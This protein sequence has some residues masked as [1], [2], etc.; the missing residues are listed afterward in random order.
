MKVNTSDEDRRG[1]SRRHSANPKGC[2]RRAFLTGTSAALAA[3]ALA[4]RPAQGQDLQKL[5]AAKQ[6]Q[7]AT[8]P[9]P[10]NRLLRDASPNGFLP[11]V[12]DHG[13]VKSFWNSFSVQHR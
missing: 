7:S 8:D 4:S 9:G 10:E 12:T 2:D 1:L 6:D 11:P 13:E 3:I 5:A